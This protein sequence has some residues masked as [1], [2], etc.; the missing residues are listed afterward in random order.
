MGIGTPLGRGRSQHLAEINMVPMIDIMLVL[1]VIFIVTAPLLTHAV[2]I[3]LPQANAEST[4]PE[5]PLELAIR[6]NGDLYWEG[7]PIDEPTLEERLRQAVQQ[8]PLA[9][10]HIRADRLTA[11]EQVA[12]S[13]AL[14]SR[15][16]LKKIG[17]ITMP[18]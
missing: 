4:Q 2:K 5:S 1:L 8:T 13:M 10:L 14:A 6:A 7:K 12:K 9:E 18:E 15:S 11:Y 16:G 3:D 17:F